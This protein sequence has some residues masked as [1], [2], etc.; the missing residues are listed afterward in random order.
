MART[1][2]QWAHYTF[3]PWWGCVQVS[4]ACDHCYAMVMAR[5][6]GHTL[7][8]H[9][10]EWG[11]GGRRGY[12]SDDKW[13]EPLDWNRAAEKHSERRR[14]FCGSMMDIFEGLREQRPYLERLFEVISQTPH[15]DWLLLTKRPNNVH[16]L[17][18]SRWPGNVWI[19]TT[20][21]TQDWADQRLPHLLATDCVVRFASVEPMLGPI[22]FRAH[23]GHGPG[24][25]NWVI[26]G[27]ESGG[28]AR[29]PESAVSWYRELRN[30]CRAAEVP[31]FFKQWGAFQQRS[32]QLVKLRPKDVRPKKGEPAV[33]DGVIWQQVPRS[34]N[35]AGSNVLHA[36]DDP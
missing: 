22:D 31:V 15:L 17:G 12:I 35:V 36:D 1:K 20:V 23:L 28:Q 26:F 3:N 27:G 18:P 33:L 13:R 7:F 21:E 14:V 24:K 34:I 32:D 5:R 11:P 2:I 16:K 6:V 10:V 29:G 25:L 4:P 19:G 9:R 30:Q 8:G